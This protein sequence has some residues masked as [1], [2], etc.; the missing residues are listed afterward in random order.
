MT[1][2][3]QMT[4]FGHSG[5]DFVVLGEFHSA[6]TKEPSNMKTGS[7]EV[8]SELQRRENDLLLSVLE[9][10]TSDVGVGA[11]VPCH[12]YH[13]FFFCRMSLPTTLTLSP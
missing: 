4:D 2:F 12:H 8:I 5:D 6:Q 3:G 1:D 10:S 13:P 11:E 7:Q 9:L